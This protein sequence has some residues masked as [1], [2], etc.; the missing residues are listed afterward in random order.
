MPM[1]DKL[2]FQ[3]RR[4]SSP[5]GEDNDN[6]CGNGIANV[7]NCNDIDVGVVV[8]QAQVPSA[9]S[10]VANGEDNNNSCGNG[11][12]NIGNCNDIDVDV[13]IG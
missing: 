12:G 1:R 2:N 6:S 5:G 7:L 13:S 11:I 3:T 4:S 10:Q 9:P 8:G